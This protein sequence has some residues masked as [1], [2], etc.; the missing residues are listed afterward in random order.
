MFK[1]TIIALALAVPGVTLAADPAAPAKS[2][3]TT[4]APAAAPVTKAVP[5]D[6]KQKPARTGERKAAAK[7][8]FA[9]ADTDGDGFL[10]RAEVEK[11]MPN[12]A[13]RFDR[14]D[15]NHDGKLS[16]DELRAWRQAAKS[17]RKGAKTTG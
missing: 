4:A 5:A 7:E 15:A 17:E 10:S 13:K 12:L 14:I 16:R 6:A 9:K 2:P 8:R 3:A 1:Q 11:G